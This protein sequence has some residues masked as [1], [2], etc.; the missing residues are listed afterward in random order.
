M[1]PRRNRTFGV[2]ASNAQLSVLPSGSFTS[3]CSQTCGLVHCI[4]VTVPSNL[5]GLFA[6]NSAAKAWCAES[7]AAPPAR[8]TPTHAIA[9]N[10]CSRIGFILQGRRRRAACGSQRL[11]QS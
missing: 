2:P 8:T 3:M 11:Y 10:V 7:R 6:S 4:L 1:N 5:T 9:A